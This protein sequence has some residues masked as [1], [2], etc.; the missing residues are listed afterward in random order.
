MSEVKQHNTM[1]ILFVVWAYLAALIPV[2][3]EITQLYQIQQSLSVSSFFI[4][5]MVTL[6]WL[7]FACGQGMTAIMFNRLSPKTTTQLAI[8]GYILSFAMMTLTN[9]PWVYGFARAGQG[10]F[11]GSMILMGRYSLSSRFKHDENLFLSQFVNIG[12]GVTIA[13][14]I[15]PMLGGYIGEAI[16]WRL[17]Y[18][19]ITSFGVLMLFNME[20]VFVFQTFKPMRELSIFKTSFFNDYTVLMNAMLCGL[21]RSMVVNYNVHMLF[22]LLHHHQWQ[23]VDYGHL[24]FGLSMVSIMCRWYLKMLKVWLGYNHLQLLIIGLA[25]LLSFLAYDVFFN[26]LGFQIVLMG[27]SINVGFGLLGTLY[28]SKAQFSIPHGTNPMMFS[29]MGVTQMLGMSLGTYLA[30]N[31]NSNSLDDLIHMSWF[32]LVLFLLAH[33]VSRFYSSNRQSINT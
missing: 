9:H 6:F 18:F 20:R 21:T 10:F 23:S 2:N 27:L 26:Q 5:K 33:M 12:I 1:T 11:C 14:S 3:F 8:W 32:F 31:L 15:M 22:H 16:H 13:N 24:L 28:S 25:W 17:I 29:I 4:K 30:I 7:M 19:V